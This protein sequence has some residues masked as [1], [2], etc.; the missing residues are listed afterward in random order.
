MM[1]ASSRGTMP[2]VWVLVSLPGVALAWVLLY[3]V[4]ARLGYPYDLEWMEGGLLTHSARI[5]NGQG[6]YVTPSVEFVPYL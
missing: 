4:F 2:L 5:A 3:T 1:A 6:I